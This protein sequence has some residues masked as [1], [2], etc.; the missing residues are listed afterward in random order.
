MVRQALVIELYPGI[1]YG[2]TRSVGVAR[3]RALPLSHALSSGD[4]HARD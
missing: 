3:G 1:P 2:F 4:S